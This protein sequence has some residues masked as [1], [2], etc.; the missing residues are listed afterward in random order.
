LLLLNQ[1]TQDALLL[2]EI[3]KQSVLEAASVPKLITPNQEVTLC[4]LKNIN[5]IIYEN[6]VK[7]ANTK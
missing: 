3:T 1:K 2:R 4:A 6:V 5:S 7:S